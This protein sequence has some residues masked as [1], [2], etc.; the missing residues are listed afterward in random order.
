MKEKHVEKSYSC[1]ISITVTNI[2]FQAAAEDLFQGQQSG[3]KQNTPTIHSLNSILAETQR[4][5][6]Q[7]LLPSLGLPTTRRQ[8]TRDAGR[9]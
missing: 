4:D 8:H 3:E 5:F 9:R 7:Y 6:Q 1:I 2:I